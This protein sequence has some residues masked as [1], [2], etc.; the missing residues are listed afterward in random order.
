MADQQLM[1]DWLSNPD[2]VLLRDVAT[3]IVHLAGV[4]RLDS[5]ALPYPASA[6]RALDALVLQCLLNG[7]RPPAGVPEMVRWGRARPLGSWPLDRL[8][9]DLFARGDRLIDEDSGEPSQLCHE[10]AVEGYSSSTGR[11]YDRLVI[12]E[13]LRACRTMASP[14][15][16]TAFRRLLVTRPVLTEADW[17]EV[18]TDLYLDPVRFLIEEIYAP[19]PLGYRRGGSYLCCH[20]C[21]TLL[22]PV[23]DKDWWCERDQCRHRGPAPHGRALAAT[24]VGQLRQLR[25]PLR[26]FV[27]GPGQA[28]VTLEGELRAMGLTVEMWPGFDAYDLRITFPDGH[29]WAVDVKD[30]AHPGLLG[31]SA[32]TVRGEPPYDEACWVVPSFRVRMRRDYLD[33]FARERRDRAGGLRLLTDDQLKRAA[34]LRLRGERG[35]EASIAARAVPP[36]AS[37]KTPR[38]ASR[39]AADK[40]GADHA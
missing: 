14:E 17:M 23:S 22:H 5:F 10:L 39:K 15:S 37:Q 28:E 18:S 27:T 36:N 6:Q 34:R 20:R 16:Y 12:Q 25:K 29:V 35:A 21:L 8:P 31:R 19:A 38:A 3:A 26:Q 13:A 40:N 33:I 1:P 9:L 24:E 4:D 2:V 7:A 30:W 32:T 11:Q